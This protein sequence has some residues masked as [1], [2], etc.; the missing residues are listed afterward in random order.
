MVAV[1]A[2]MTRVFRRL[3]PAVIGA[4]ATACGTTP[5]LSSPPSIQSIQF[6]VSTIAPGSNATY[7]FN[8]SETSIVGV[9]LASVTSVAT[10]DILPSALTLALG[11]PSGS[12]CTPTT[13]IDTSLALSAQVSKTLSAG[14]YCVKVTDVDGLPESATFTVRIIATTG[15]TPQKATGL[16]TTESFA[17]ELQV[18][19]F[20]MRTFRVFAPGNLAAT[21]TG[22]G[23]LDK[24]VRVSLGV[25]D[26][27]VCRLAS[28]VDT[29]AG[30]PAQI[31]AGVDPGTYCLGLRDIGNLKGPVSFS[32]SVEHP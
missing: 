30:S 5:T 16:T 29:A 32:V 15:S 8:V 17:S 25:W 20:S 9:T 14:A 12:S 2:Y 10:G 3:L 18:G 27:S 28:S 6:V 7:S 22:A 23:G 31:V 11:T 13:S 24:V 1:P 4:F 26:G 21:L 19:G